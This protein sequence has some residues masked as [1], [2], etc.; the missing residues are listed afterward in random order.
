MGHKHKHK[1]ES[2]DLSYKFYFGIPHAHTSNS[3]GKGTPEEAL[4]HTKS[5]GLHYLVITDH[6]R[7][8]SRTVRDKKKERDK[9]SD[10]KKTLQHFNKKDKYFLGIQGFEL[11]I[12]SI[13]DVNIIN[14]NNHIK[15]SVRD[16]NKLLSW[17][18]EEKCIGVINH[19]GPNVE[20]L[21]SYIELNEYITLIEVGN[22]SPPF[23]YTR[24]FKYYFKLLDAGWKLGA[25]NGQDNHSNNWGEA[26]NLTVVL[27][28]KLSSKHLL[29]SLKERRTYSTESRTL[30]LVYRINGAWMGST[31][32]REC[33]KAYD[34]L[35]CIEDI[36]NPVEKIQIITNGGK[37]IKEF[38][39]NMEHKL[40]YEFNLEAS[41]EE[42]WYVV[43][44]FQ[45]KDKIAISSPVFIQ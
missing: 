34:F 29:E 5:R 36:E 35:I 31:I 39:C 25:V 19:P 44:V 41:N 43:K 33:G 1:K 16:L 38:I 42:S 8:L 28:E 17:I 22:G 13:G 37:V 6:N 10:L 9:W 14:S 12:K 40:K 21:K 15:G 26:S 24:Y 30:K 7:Y 2:K 23:K 27:S 45:I 11:K 3:T 18:Q 20:K 32:Q 4:R